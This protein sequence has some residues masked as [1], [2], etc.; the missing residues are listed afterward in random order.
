MS[1]KTPTTRVIIND[2]SVIKGG[3]N[4]TSQ[5]TVRPPPPTPTKPK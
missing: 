1:D 3:T 2:G 5:V 4:T